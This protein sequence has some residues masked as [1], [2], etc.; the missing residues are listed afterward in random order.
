VQ[1]AE[2]SLYHNP[3]GNNIGHS[4]LSGPNDCYVERIITPW[5]EN[6]VTWN[7]QPATTA[8]NSIIFP[9]STSNSQDY[10]NVDVTALVQDMI[11][12]PANSHGFMIRLVN[13]QAYR[14]MKFA[15]GDYPN[16]QLHPLLMI[17]TNAPNAVA[18]INSPSL[19]DVYP[20]PANERVYLRFND[21]GNER[22]VIVHDMDGRIVLFEDCKEKEVVLD[23]SG[24]SGGVYFITVTS[25]G[26]TEIKK[27]VIVN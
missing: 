6:T 4:T 5:L 13:E 26:H 20:N 17:I 14:S 27:L 8:Q 23:L 22:K 15:S 2:L 7:N 25:E 11:A 10:L 16:S 3:G 12:D 19:T 24:I 18:E 21:A 1:K 9:A